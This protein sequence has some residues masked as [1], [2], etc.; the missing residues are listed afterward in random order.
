MSKN[1]KHHPRSCIQ[2]LT[3]PRIDGG[4][5]FIDI[6]NLH[7]KQ[8]T[9]LRKFFH[10]KAPTVMLHNAIVQNDK[11]LTPLNLADNT[12][13]RNETLISKCDK[14]AAWT[15]KSLHGRHIQHLNL[16]HVDKAASNAWLKRG[17]LFPET[18]GFMLAIQDQV[19]ETHKTIHYNRPDI[20]LIDKH[21]KNALIIDIAVP[22]THNLPNTITEKLTKYTELKQEITKMWK[23]QNV[24][25][26][27]IV[28]STTGVIPTQL[29][30][31]IELL[32]LPKH[33][34]MQL[35][36][37][38]ILNTCRIVVRYADLYAASF[39]N[40]MYYPFCYM[41]RAPAMLMP[42]ESTVAH[43]QRFTVDTPTIDRTRQ[44]SAQRAFSTT[45]IA[46]VSSEDVSTSQD[47][48]DTKNSASVPHVRPETPRRLTHTHD[49]DCSDDEDVAKGNK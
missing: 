11:K 24:I 47:V 38:A 1:R 48:N 25:I 14:L 49:E 40:L 15:Q 3:L 23:L 18:E 45:Y 34:Y 12:T 43:E 42:H 31:Y 32:H 19:I 39:L 16:P 20:T 46:E 22:N 29:H 10:T 2:R 28:L 5:G 9:T 26:V 30:K 17:E 41:F 33:T 13:Q 6:V 7:N 37:A 8:I 35:Q 36:K 4:R 27:P 44:T 21:E